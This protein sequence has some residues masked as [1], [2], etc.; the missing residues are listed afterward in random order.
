M[1]M[2]EN[3]MAEVAKLFGKKLGEEFKVKLTTGEVILCRFSEKRLWYWQRDWFIS[4]KVLVQLI[5]G[6]AVIVNE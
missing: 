3:K 2:A 1:K 4:D 6:E 5:V